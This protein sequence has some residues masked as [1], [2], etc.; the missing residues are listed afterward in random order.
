MNRTCAAIVAQPNDAIAGIAAGLQNFYNSTGNRPC[1]DI[2]NDVPDWGTGDGWP[3]LACEDCALGVGC[4]GGGVGLTVAATVFFPQGQR[5]M[6]WPAL[7]ANIPYWVQECVVQFNL[8][9]RVDWA[10][11]QF[12]GTDFSQVRSVG[13]ARR[14]ARPDR[15]RLAR[16]RAI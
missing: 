1:L 2:V 15:Q 16:R 12:G 4:G 6:W 5:G 14:C 13:V 8:T 7:G 9:L 10:A 3:I 11:T